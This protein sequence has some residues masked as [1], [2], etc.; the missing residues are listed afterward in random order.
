ML[1]TGKRR[2]STRNESQLRL[3]R[4]GCNP[5][6]QLRAPSCGIRPESESAAARGVRPISSAGR[7]GTSTSGRL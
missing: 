4:E 3:G 6:R 5:L 7:S 2:E 1:H